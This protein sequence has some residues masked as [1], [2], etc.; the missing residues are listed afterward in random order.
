MKPK[1]VRQLTSELRA[2]LEKN[3][4]AESDAPPEMRAAFM[5]GFDL[6]AGMA[7]NIACLA[8][9]AEPRK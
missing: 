8:H 7:Y 2:A 1:Q 4:G 3:A 6:L 9:P 5:Q